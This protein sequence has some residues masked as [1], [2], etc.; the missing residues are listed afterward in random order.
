MEKPQKTQSKVGKEVY[1][2]LFLVPLLWGTTFI[3]TKHL[4]RGIPIFS[5][6]CIRHCI[7]LIG[8]IPAFRK[9]KHANMRII[10]AGCLTGGTNFFAIA[11]QTYGLLTTTS[12]KAGFIT[13][14]YIVL[15][16]IF[17]WMFYGR[18]IQKK[19]IIA[20]IL[21]ASGLGLLMLDPKNLANSE[22]SSIFAVGDLY[23]AGSAVLFAFQLIFTEGFVKEKRIK[24]IVE[25]KKL[26]NDEIDPILFVIL[27]LI[28]IVLFS[29]LFSIFF[30][31]NI[32]QL[33]ISKTE[34]WLFIYLG[35]LGTTLPFLFHNWGQKF[36]SSDKTGIIFSTEP[37][38]ATLFG[39]WIDREPFSW[40][41]AIG[42]VLIMVSIMIVLKKPRNKI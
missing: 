3:V 4:T 19:I 16:P 15:I 14:L 23:I 34:G 31:E 21:S 2:A 41:L 24:E 6:T 33:P 38:F 40:R 11:L 25:S 18:K 22:N 37:I 5:L 36:I 32:F 1:L 35:I 28:A 29:F 30:Q 10:Q 39:I 7:A 17:L 26:G 12:G 42:G 13:S 27:Q 8:F 20:V 9:L